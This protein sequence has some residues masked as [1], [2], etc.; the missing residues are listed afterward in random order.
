MTDHRL[1]IENRSAV[2]VPIRKVE[3]A[4][5]AQLEEFAAVYGSVTWDLVRQLDRQ[6]FRIVLRDHSDDPDALAWHWRLG[7]RP[8]ATVYAGDIMAADDGDAI[9]GADSVSAAISHEVVELLADPIALYYVDGLD[10]WMYALEIADPVQD[11]VYEIDGVSVSNFVYP[12]Y[13]N[14]WAARTRTR[15]LDRMRLVT[16]PFEVR[17]GGYL[18]RYKGRRRSYVE[19]HK[20][21]IAERRTKESKPNGRT[22]RRLEQLRRTGLQVRLPPLGGTL[23]AQRIA[24]EA[25]TRP[26]TAGT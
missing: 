26:P 15:S 1:R 10:D 17:E 11:D 2:A 9:E 18:L 5:A 4:I 20:F 7:G 13:W 6:G 3:R 22:R 8:T 23:A 14:P 12:D 21:P 16:R 24:R 19:G 25:A